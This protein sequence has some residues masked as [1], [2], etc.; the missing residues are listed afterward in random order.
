MTL[1][2]YYINYNYSL[3]QLADQFPLPSHISIEGRLF[4][5][6]DNLE[7]IR[8]GQKYYVE[9]LE[10]ANDF[11]A[12]KKILAVYY[13][14]LYFDCIFDI[15]KSIQFETIIENIDSFEAIPV[16]K[17]LFEEIHKLQEKE[18]EN[19]SQKRTNQQ[20]AAGIG[21]LDKYGS[22]GTIDMLAGGDP[23]KYESISQLSWSIAFLKLKL[24]KDRSDYEKNLSEIMRK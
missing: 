22:F 8:I 6:P 17:H 11:E 9:S 10:F 13:Q 5:V 20:I 23:L 2:E 21:K 7:Q 12:V 18:S 19:L 14:P 1:K 3:H 16:A 24:E 15:D 4:E